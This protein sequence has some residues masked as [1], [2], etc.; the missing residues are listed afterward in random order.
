MNLLKRFSLFAAL[1]INAALFLT[2]LNTHAK[3]HSQNPYNP[4]LMSIESLNYL[5]PTSVEVNDLTY[6]YENAPTKDL[7]DLAP[8]ADTVK[9]AELIVDKIIN[10]GQKIWNVVE[11]GKPSA[12]YTSAK[13]SAVPAN[14]TRWDQLENWKAPRSKVI[15]VVY[16]NLYGAEVVRFIYRINLLYGGSANGIGKYIGYASVEPVEISVSYM[17]TFNATAS[18][19]AVYNMGTNAT[20]LAGMLL[21]INWTVETV[22][23]K[24]TQTHT[25]T[26]DGNGNIYDPNGAIT[27]GTSSLL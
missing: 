26:L 2:P 13:A 1:L 27:F 23:K 16:K 5:T 6:L 9:Q 12:T 14:T 21:S 25:F 8:I 17:Y 15:S 24:T 7:A 18:V 4:N 20:P 3:I 10:I 22:L 11:K 19:D